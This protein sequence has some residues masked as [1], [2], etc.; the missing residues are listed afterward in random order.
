M[1]P[2]VRSPVLMT[3]A[4]GSAQ[5]AVTITPLMI[6]TTRYY[7]WWHRDPLDMFGDALSNGLEVEFCD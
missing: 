5:Y 7:Q 2:T 6:G 3:T 1:S 4:S